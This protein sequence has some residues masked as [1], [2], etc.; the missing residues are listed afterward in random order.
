MRLLDLSGVSAEILIDPE[1]CRPADQPRVCGSHHKL[2]EQTGWNPEIPLDET[3][4]NLYRYWEN[5]LNGN[6]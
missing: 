5:I 4:L 2:I 1:R 6:K 3:L